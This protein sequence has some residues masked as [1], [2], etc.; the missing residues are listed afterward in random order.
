MEQQR[1][2]M[3]DRQTITFAVWGGMFIAA[4]LLVTTIW[5]SN[6]ARVGTNQAVNRVSEFYLEE[7][8]GRRAQVVSEE[9]KNNVAYMENTLNIMEAS[10]LESQESLR[11][12]LG[13][14]KK[15]YDVDKFAL[16]D[17]NGI[18]YTQHST[19]SGLS[20]YHFLSEELTEPVISTL[21]LYGAR[22]QVV[23][24]I[25]AEGISFQGTEIKACFIQI[26][27]DEMLSSLT[28]QANGN[29]TY[30]NLYHRSGESLTN[31]A[32]GN[33]KAGDNLF[34]V[35][36]DADTA[37]KTGYKQ[38][39]EDFE[40]GR[41]GQI[42]FEYQG[43]Q[44]DLCYVPVEGTNWMLAILI[45]DN[46]LREQISSISSGMMTRGVIQIVI[47]V[48]AMLALFHVL[49]KQS[50]K[51]ARILLE[52]E[53]EDGNRIRAAYAQIEREQAAMRNIQAA[54]GS[55]MWGIEFN[56]QAEIT[57]CSWSETFRSMLGYHS[58]AEFPNRLE[59]WSDLL[60]E[61]DKERS[62]EE[63]WDTVK[64]YTGEKTYDVEYRLLTRNAGWRW[65]HAAGRLSRRED[66]SPVSFVGLF[67][68][69][70]D[71]KKMEARLEKQT[72]DLQDALAAAQHANRAKT[73]FLNNMS[74]DIRTPMNA[75]IGF[76]SLAAAHIDNTEQ[77][78][79]Y[80]S[81]I[82]TS[83]NHLLSL[84]NDVLDMSRIE[85]GKVK[86]EE[87]ET[88]LP[89]IMHDLKTIVQADITSKQLEF[90]I[91]TA[92]VVNEHVLC[93]KLRLNQ[94]LLNLLSNAMKFTKPG[95]IVSVR[96]LQKGNAPEGCA[97]Y[98]FQVKDTGI[99]M[100]KEF[101]E[102]VFEPFER[103]QT[104]T[105]SG[106]QGTG[107][108]MAI[109][110]NIVDMMG[111]KIS[112]DSEIGKGS[113]FH[114]E[115]QFKTCS[116]SVRQEVIPELNG[117]RA[118]V[119]DDDFNTCSS[120]TKML[121]TIGMRPDWTTSGKEAVLRT[122]LAEEQNDL[123]SAYIIDWLMP[124]MNGIEVVRRIRGII[125]EETPIII[126]T[127]YD[128]SDIE[129][130]ARNAGV[131]AFCSKPIF[132]SEL[133]E[134]L[135]SPFT[136]L[137]AE[138]DAPE[139]S[140]SF[141][142][143]KILLVEDNELNQEIAVEILQEAGFVLDV[144][145]DGAVAVEKMKSAKPGQY[146]LILMDIQMPIM[147]G[148][149]ATGQ[150]RGLEDPEIAGIPIIAMTANAFEEDKKAAADAGMNGHIAKPIDVPIL[151]DVLGEIL[152]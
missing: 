57:S 17:E 10:D 135:E 30:C 150:I 36:M 119:A 107:L 54:M 35:V 43:Y 127:A 151:L 80:L 123:Y 121:S 24:A 21:N 138:K 98:E 126:L 41:Q 128:W 37:A 58:E 129:E 7:L 27:I 49:A 96:I 40:N 38:L 13:K 79:D 6:G 32:F 12:F 132:L 141:E 53:K 95:G 33:V 116:G 39:R 83:S 47:T 45:R 31:E 62:V 104:S 118:L 14:V 120:V 51:H 89:E 142:G 52:Q 64:D 9:L 112:V 133:R 101:L 5:V 78:Q 82:T 97:S 88:S 99:G 102:H 73:T 29:E 25:P 130:E 87:K 20:R 145:D 2:R 136:N 144:A 50:R 34:S 75:I 146:D 124:D 8:A 105:V 100:S 149:E 152:K 91:D 67:L 92:D 68:D 140:I 70:D 60:H 94:V 103:E 63:F 106:I 15:L 134:V 48:L 3:K 1:K 113:T 86:I 71:E 76:T 23:L 66:G 108:G 109:T 26:N 137:G 16:V 147:D 55:G 143:K 131:T 19:T 44:E 125:G 11:T 84:I 18:V 61:E 22:K 117:L 4:L 46:V 28:L 81:K 148:Y 42:T 69:I 85:S 90:Y 72:I 139:E 122:R 110:K 111:G 74:H 56:E 59:S 77:V 93:D 65:F 115:L 114:V